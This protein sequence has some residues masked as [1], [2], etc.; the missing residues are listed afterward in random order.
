[1]RKPDVEVVSADGVEVVREYRVHIAGHARAARIVD[2]E[3]REDLVRVRSRATVV[4]EVAIPN[5]TAVRGMGNPHLVE[6]L[7]LADVAALRGVRDRVGGDPLDIEVACLRVDL[8]VARDRVAERLD[9]GVRIV[10]EDIRLHERLSAVVR[11]R[12][13]DL[14]RGEV[15]VCDVDGVRCRRDLA[16]VDCEPWPIDKG[17]V[18]GGD[19]VHSPCCAAVV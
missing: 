11:A 7:D 19:V 18:E 3:C 16:C 10:G 8:D 1:M 4:D 13:P 2:A 6:V 9:F 5:E 17:W 15:V 14:A 12:D